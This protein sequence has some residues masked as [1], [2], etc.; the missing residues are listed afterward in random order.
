[1]LPT[2]AVS[3]PRGSAKIGNPKV[4]SEHEIPLKSRWDMLPADPSA[5]RSPLCYLRCYHSSVSSQFADGRASDRDSIVVVLLHLL[6]SIQPWCQ[7][8][9]VSTS[10]RYSAVLQIKTTLAP[11]CMFVGMLFNVAT[12][13]ACSSSSSSAFSSSCLPVC[14]SACHRRDHW[15]AVGILPGVPSSCLPVCLS[16]SYSVWHQRGH[17]T[18]WRDFRIA[19]R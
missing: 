15:H 16:V 10:R 12:S 18:G 2:I 3:H 14:S 8:A 9:C 6:S 7:A 4:I 17:S 1:M 13:L 19:R 11:M 5:N